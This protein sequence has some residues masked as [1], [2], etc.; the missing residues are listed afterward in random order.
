MSDHGP[1]TSPGFWLHHAYLAWR[2]ACEARLGETTYPQFNILSAISLVTRQS[3][4]PPTQQQAADAA[5][6]DRK[7]ASKLIATLE[8]KA[9]VARVPDPSD[10]RARRL[11]LTEAGR[12]ALRSC[13]AAARQADAEVFGAGPDIDH[14]LRQLHAIAE[15]RAP[16]S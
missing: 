15:R 2:A 16:A 13:V 3:G 9:L 1:H 11:R 10:A 14:L 8:D 4:H 7:M 5:R 6:I 12:Q